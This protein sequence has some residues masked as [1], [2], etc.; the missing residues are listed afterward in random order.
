MN[1][2]K[3]K[4]LKELFHHK[5]KCLDYLSYDGADEFQGVIDEL[6]DEDSFMNHYSLSFL[7]SQIDE[8]TE[9]IDM[10]ML[11]RRLPDHLEE[12]GLLAHQLVNVDRSF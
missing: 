12:D 8:V 4:E 1:I 9:A 10:E 6:E 5:I 2:D 11:K 3:F 7:Q